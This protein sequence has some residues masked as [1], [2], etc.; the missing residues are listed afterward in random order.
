M[1]IKNLL[2]AAAACYLIPLG[3]LA[4]TNVYDDIIAI[5]PN[6]TYLKA[7]LDQEGLDAALVQ[8]PN[9]TVFAPTNDAFDALS[10]IHI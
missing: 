4:Q 6:H 2:F 3:S 10:L 8:N 7:A 1:N 9:V 5:S